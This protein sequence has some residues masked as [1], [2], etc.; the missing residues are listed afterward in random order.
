MTNDDAVHGLAGPL[1]SHSFGNGYDRSF[2]KDQIWNE[3]IRQRN[4][5]IDR[6]TG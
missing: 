3:E 1:R 4:K 5:V 6:V 2:F